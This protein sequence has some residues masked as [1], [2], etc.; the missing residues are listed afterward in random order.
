MLGLDRRRLFSPRLGLCVL[1]SFRA[2]CRRLRL[3]CRQL[4]GGTATGGFLSRLARVHVRA[5]GCLRVRLQVV[6]RHLVSSYHLLSDLDDRLTRVCS[7]CRCSIAIRLGL[8]DGKRVLFARPHG[9]Q[10][11]TLRH[12]SRVLRFL[13]GTL[14]VRL[15]LPRDRCLALCALL[16][17][18]SL[19]FG[20]A[21]RR[22]LTLSMPLCVATP[23]GCCC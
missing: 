23:Q 20:F 8:G 15:G 4:L 22:H 5:R 17:Q 12:R 7:I 18:P 16:C 13:L 10:L 9:V 6:I 19:R 3:L 21:C 1:G 2:L 14:G 11:R